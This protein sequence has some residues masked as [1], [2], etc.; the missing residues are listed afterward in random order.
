[1]VLRFVYLSGFSSHAL[2]HKNKNHKMIKGAPPALMSNDLKAGGCAF[3]RGVPFFSTQPKFEINLKG[4]LL[5]M[6]P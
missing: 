5:G 4:I 2:G 3:F 6:G 1:M